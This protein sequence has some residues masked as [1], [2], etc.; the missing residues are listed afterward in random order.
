MST[1]TRTHRYN[2]GGKTLHGFKQGSDLFSELLQR[3]AHILQPRPS[4]LTFTVNLYGFDRFVCR[5]AARYIFKYACDSASMHPLSK[6][7]LP[8]QPRETFFKTLSQILS[9]SSAVQPAVVQR[10]IL[11]CLRH[12]FQH[13]IE[14]LVS[15]YSYRGDKCATR[16]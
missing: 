4:T 6:R 13:L 8:P 11:S 10:L 16:R 12:L 5:F 9:H 14:S 2:V 15:P 3:C 7:N 1:L